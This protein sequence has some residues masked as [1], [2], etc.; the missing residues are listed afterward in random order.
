VTLRKLPNSND[1]S[2]RTWSRG[3]DVNGWNNGKMVQL[4]TSEWASIWC[5]VIG[6]MNTNYR[7]GANQNSP[8][9]IRSNQN[10]SRR[11]FRRNVRIPGWDD[12]NEYKLNPTYLTLPFR[13]GCCV[14]GVT[15]AISTLYYCKVAILHSVCFAFQ[16]A[17]ICL[18]KTREFHK[19]G[20]V[21]ICAMTK[22]RTCFTID[23][24]ASGETKTRHDVTL[25]LLT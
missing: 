12:L 20:G 4:S 2:S 7:S 6:S 5:Y 10:K 9:L 25:P 18:K 1:V 8:G 14:S 13:A 11:V 24:A 19:F 17:C 15:E 23:G 22:V 16:C 3:N 21:G